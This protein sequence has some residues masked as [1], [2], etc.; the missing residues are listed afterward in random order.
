MGDTPMSEEDVNWCELHAAALQRLGTATGDK[1]CAL[2][3]DRRRL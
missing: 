2:L 3:D 1:L